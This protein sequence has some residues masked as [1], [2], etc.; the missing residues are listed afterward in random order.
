MRLSVVNTA[1]ERVVQ[2]ISLGLAFR[3][4]APDVVVSPDGLTLYVSA[5][6]RVVV[7][8]ASTLTVTHTIPTLRVLSEMVRNA[9]GS[10]LY[11]VGTA[12][13][14]LSQPFKLSGWAADTTVPTGS[15]STRPWSRA[16]CR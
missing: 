3:A 5:N 9:D 7:I 8:D 16:R 13:G 6:K 12:S 11:V 2:S 14:S 1:T 10:R 15:G 4:A